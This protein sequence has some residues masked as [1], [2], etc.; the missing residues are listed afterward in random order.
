MSRADATITLVHKSKY[1]RLIFLLNLSKDGVRRVFFSGLLELGLE[2][3]QV[4]LWTSSQVHFLQNVG[5]GQSKI[6]DP[7]AY[8][9]REED[10]RARSAQ[11]VT[12][13]FLVS[14]M[15]VCVGDTHSFWAHHLLNDII[16]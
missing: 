1:I 4:R 13:D 8:S 14:P 15:E 2:A 3:L 6:R 12:A 10:V 5:Q 11:E 7:E 16:S 9:V